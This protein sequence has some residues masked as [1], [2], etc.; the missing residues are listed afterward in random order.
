MLNSNSFL[1]TIPKL[2]K[3]DKTPSP[4]T[5]QERDEICGAFEE[6]PHYNYYAPLIRFLFFTGAR[7]SEA[8]GLQWKC[9]DRSLNF[10]TFSQAWVAGEFKDTK[11]HKSRRFPINNAVKTLLL[12]IRPR[13]VKPND[14]VFPSKTGLVVDPH[15][16]SNR[17]WKKILSSLGHIQYRKLYC[18]RHT[19][20]SVCLEE[21]V[22]VNIISG[23]VGNC[24][25]TIWKSYAGVVSPVPVP[26]P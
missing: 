9:I 2:R 7:P 10:I 24:P 11:T 5:R 22:P 19:F 8:V 18:T 25:S 4:F 1:S 17:A 6:S 20:I 13:S 26:E 12:E 16:L 15:N 21:G 23:W 3:G 14:L